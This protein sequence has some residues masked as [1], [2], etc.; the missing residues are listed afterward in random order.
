MIKSS[1]SCRN[2]GWCGRCCGRTI[3]CRTSW[4]RL[5]EDDLESFIK[6]LTTLGRASSTR[7]HHVQ[8]IRA[9]SRWAV[10]KG[11]R[12]TPMISDDSDVI[13]R[14]KEAQRHR[15]LEPGEEERLLLVVGGPSGTIFA[16]TSSAPAQRGVAGPPAGGAVRRSQVPGTP[17]IGTAGRQTA[18]RVGTRCKELTGPRASESS[19]T[20]AL[21]TQTEFPHPTRSRER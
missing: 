8:L 4:A 1:R 5:T 11:Y 14:R 21:F 15:R 6:H 3:S 13:R 18:G 20:G 17:S 2:Q 9:M 16:T 10:K 12:N 19:I 7:N